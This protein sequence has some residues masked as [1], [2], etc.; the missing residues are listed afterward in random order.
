MGKSKGNQTKKSK[1]RKEREANRM[2]IYQVKAIKNTNKVNIKMSGFI[3]D[4]DEFN[5]ENIDVVKDIMDGDEKSVQIVEFV[6]ARFNKPNISSVFL[7]SNKKLPVLYAS[8]IYQK[9]LVMGVLFNMTI[10][11]EITSDTLKIDSID[12]LLDTELEGKF[13]TDIMMDEKIETMPMEKFSGYPE[14][15]KNILSLLK[16][17]T[18]IEIIKQ[19]LN[20]RDEERRERYGCLSD[21]RPSIPKYNFSDLVNK[22]EENE[23][24]LEKELEI[25]IQKE[26]DAA[27][28][29]KIKTK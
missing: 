1:T 22:S 18:M 3:N 2:Y 4:G 6:H 19:Q 8:L 15:I 10:F 17:E 13:T 28:Q 21:Y 14:T 27:I 29:K 7:L 12:Q 16:S 11:F 23:E 5:D 24:E 9:P 26:M 20:K 25:E